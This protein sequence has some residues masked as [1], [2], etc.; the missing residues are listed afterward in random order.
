MSTPTPTP[1]PS[2]TCAS[3]K[4]ITDLV[5]PTILSSIGVLTAFAI[6]FS[7]KETFDS[8]VT[9]KNKY[10]RVILAWAYSIL[11]FGIAI[12]LIATHQDEVTVVKCG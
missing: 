7:V 2:T 5:M 9:T 12:A 3:P 8:L 11:V 1:T 10:Y 6:T 4:K